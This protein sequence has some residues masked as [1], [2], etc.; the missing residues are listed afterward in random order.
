MISR[1]TG[2]Q[3]LAVLPSTT[4]VTPQ[5]GAYKAADIDADY[6]ANLTASMTGRAY[7][8]TADALTAAGF[9]LITI[10]GE[11]LINAN[12]VQAFR[13]L[14]DCYENTRIIKQYAGDKC[15][16]LEIHDSRMGM[17]KNQLCRAIGQLGLSEPINCFSLASYIGAEIIDNCNG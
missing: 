2:T 5:A 12:R 4:G 16:P 10:S 14:I 17:L 3:A 6:T 9:S 7:T 1:L 11:D 13:V 15:E 8:W